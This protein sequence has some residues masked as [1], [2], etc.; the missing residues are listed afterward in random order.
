MALAGVARLS[1][2][3]E[4]VRDRLHP[5]LKLAHLLACRMDTRTNLA[6]EVLEA[7]RVRFGEKVLDTVVRESVRIRE[8]WGYAQPILT[9]DPNGAGAEDY[10]AAAI[11]ILNRHHALERS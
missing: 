5:K 8:A 2:T 3:V 11:E 4:L 10:R 1:E 9:Y 6:R 7:L